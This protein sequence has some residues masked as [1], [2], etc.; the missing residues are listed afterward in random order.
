M[1]RFAHV[2]RNGHKERHLSSL[3][4]SHCFPFLPRLIFLSFFV[5]TSFSFLVESGN[6]ENTQTYTRQLIARWISKNG[7]SAGGTT[8]KQGGGGGAIA[9]AFQNP[10]DVVNERDRIEYLSV[11]DDVIRFLSDEKVSHVC[12]K[13]RKLHLAVVMF[14][15]S[16]TVVDEGDPTKTCAATASMVRVVDEAGLNDTWIIRLL[17]EQR[18]LLV[19]M[20][21][22]GDLDV[23]AKSCHRARSLEC[24]C[25]AISYSALYF[26]QQHPFTKKLERVNTNQHRTA[27]QR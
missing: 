1:V 23:E 3:H 6:R 26:G 7:S 13:H 15:I 4:Q 22:L 5:P 12:S 27:L 14:Q 19:H 24:L 16:R 20:A 2:Y 25:D 11:M 21:S 8:H 9:A 18:N 17:L 10:T